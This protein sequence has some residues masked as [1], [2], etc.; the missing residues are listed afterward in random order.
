VSSDRESRTTHEDQ[1]HAPRPG[2]SHPLARDNVD[3]Y[4]VVRLTRL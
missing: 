4:G 2:A 3:G 1:L